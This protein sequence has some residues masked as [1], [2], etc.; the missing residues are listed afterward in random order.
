MPTAADD[1]LGR[2]SR[3]TRKA[4]DALVSSTMDVAEFQKISNGRH[5]AR[6]LA[7]ACRGRGGR[8]ADAI[9]TDGVS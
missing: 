4:V 8:T 5:S 6:A 1:E 7:N 2:L 3:A 9:Q